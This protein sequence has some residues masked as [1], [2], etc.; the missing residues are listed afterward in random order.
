MSQRE[1]DDVPR[2]PR[3]DHASILLRPSRRSRRNS[4]A[5]LSTDRDA[6]LGRTSCNPRAWRVCGRVSARRPVLCR[7]VSSGGSGLIG[8][9]RRPVVFGP[10]GEPRPAAFEAPV[11]QLDHVVMRNIVVESRAGRRGRGPTR[12]AEACK[13]CRP[14]ALSAQRQGDPLAESALEAHGSKVPAAAAE[15]ASACSE[16]LDGRLN[17]LVAGR[18][19][20]LGHVSHSGNMPNCSSARCER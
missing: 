10:D 17:R 15:P 11:G 7:C 9:G 3:R 13:T 8:T 2:R 4:R 5:R 16:A 19:R 18:R 20:C 1:D 6:T 12:F 14:S